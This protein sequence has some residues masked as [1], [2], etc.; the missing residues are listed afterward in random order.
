MAFNLLDSQ[1]Q[2]FS[3]IDVTLNIAL[4]CREMGIE[5]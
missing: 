5:I 1:G 4:S 3:P 2:E